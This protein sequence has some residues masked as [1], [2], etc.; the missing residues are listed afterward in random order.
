MPRIK[1]SAMNVYQGC[2]IDWERSKETHHGQCTAIVAAKSWKEAHRILVV[3][4]RN[5]TLG[6]IRNY[7]S[8]TGNKTQ[9]DAATAHPHKILL[10][11]SSS[12]D[13]YELVS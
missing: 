10:S 7:W 6:H 4:Y 9:I 5:M 8:I 11:S 13:D 3:R 2:V 1:N 12:S